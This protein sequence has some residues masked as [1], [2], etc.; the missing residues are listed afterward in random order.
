VIPVLCA[1]VTCVW[2]ANEM[3]VVGRNEY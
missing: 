1:L 2:N 3:D